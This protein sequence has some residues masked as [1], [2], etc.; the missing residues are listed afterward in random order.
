MGTRRRAFGL[1]A[2]A[3]AERYLVERKGWT[4]VGRN[5]R[6]GRAEADLIGQ[7]PDGSLRAVEVKGARG[8]INPDG[9]VRDIPGVLPVD[10]L[11]REQMARVA[12]VLREWRAGR[13]KVRGTAWAVDACLVVVDVAA[14]RARV[15]HVEALL[16]GEW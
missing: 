2:Q 15:E 5:I 6:A 1:L 14:L 7:A 16:G 4:I 9:S 11:T 12:R 3:L 8:A 10:H 13:G